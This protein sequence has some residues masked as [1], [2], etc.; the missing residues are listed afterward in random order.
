[1]NYEGIPFQHGIIKSLKKFN[2]NLK[3]ICYLHC[4]GW[5]VQTDL[6]YREKSI[7]TLL[8]SGEDQKLVMTSYLNWPESKI[9]SIPSLRFDKKTK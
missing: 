5:P 8:V 4:A 6:I 3:I 9:F 7:D 1:M 2:N